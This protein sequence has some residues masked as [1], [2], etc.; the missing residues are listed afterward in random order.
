MTEKDL[1]EKSLKGFNDIFADI[2][3]VLIFL[4]S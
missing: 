3:N 4:K 2:V 1:S